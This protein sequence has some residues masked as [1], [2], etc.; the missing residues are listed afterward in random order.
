M[1]S[2]ILLSMLLATVIGAGLLVPA[3]SAQ[4]AFP[5]E[6]DKVLFVS[7]RDRGSEG[8][9]YAMHPDGTGLV[10]LTDSPAY[11]DGPVWSP[12]GSKIAF[13]SDYKIF[14]MNADGSDQTRLTGGSGQYSDPT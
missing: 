6:N 12:D 5:D 10:R 7:Y 2:K 4:A 1:K 8:D 11:E 13:R 14:V 9:I 3:S